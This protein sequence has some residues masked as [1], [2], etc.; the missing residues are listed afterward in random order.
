M[1]S[2]RCSVAQRAGARNAAV[3]VLIWLAYS[4]L[5]R[6]ETALSPFLDLFGPVDR[7]A[8]AGNGGLTVAV[9]PFGRISSCRWPSPGYHNQVSYR[10]CTAGSHSK[11]IPPSHGIMWGIRWGGKTNW[12]TGAPWRTTQV[13]ADPAS[14]TITTSAT[15]GDTTI[16]ARQAVLVHPVNDVMFT[17]LSIEDLSES[18]EIFWYSNFTPC[19]RLIPEAPIADWLLDDLNDFAC[20]ALEDGR[21]LV[22]FRPK[23]PG[24]REWAEAQDIVT[25]ATPEEL[26]KQFK[27]G[28]WIAY[29]ALE[30]VSGF[31]CGLA[32]GEGC[33]FQQACDGALSNCPRAVGGANSVIRITPQKDADCLRATVVAAFGE[34]LQQTLDRLQE[35]VE[36]GFDNTVETARAHW[37]DVLN[38]VNTASD[39]S[40]ASFQKQCLM[41]VIMATDRITNA[42]VRAPV[43]RPPPALNWPAQSAWA[44]LAL[45]MAGKNEWAAA[46]L[47]FL[48]AT[49]RRTD[50]PGRPAGSLPAAVYANGEDAL[51]SFVLDVDAVGWFLW[52]IW[53]HSTF[54]PPEE[55]AGFLEQHWE[56]IELATDFLVNWNNPRTSEP[57]PSFRPSMLRDAQD[58]DLL[59]HVVMGLAGS[60]RIAETLGRVR[61]DVQ[62]RLDR[63][64][65]LLIARLSD[66]EQPNLTT[67]LWPLA[68]VLNDTAVAGSEA[69]RRLQQVGE[70]EADE[71]RWALFCDLALM[72]DGDP[73][74]TAD[75]RS[76]IRAELRRKG[77]PLFLLDS[78]SAAHAYI[79]IAAAF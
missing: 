30:P 26:D 61:P 51:P 60:L 5:A 22:H 39:N 63:C 70:Y 54:L 78:T 41:H 55:R 28:T 46:H 43:N 49:V 31:Q 64:Q 16:Q 25:T 18:S 24:S 11:N 42:I 36:C 74:M 7:S 37:E 50:A 75:V 34:T 6:A 1:V 29:T 13:P 4:A 72:A 77:P 10:P 19:T 45:D 32:D 52:I 59:A 76:L 9:N 35:G 69:Q 14:P 66:N 23:D 33:A 17:Q 53:K 12:V 21:I 48:S 57:L 47:E 2:R 73:Q 38:G 79:A 68:C 3:L 65:S 58:L 71:D 56:P 8:F 27:E 15:F 62:R 40:L 67:A 44:A 20:I